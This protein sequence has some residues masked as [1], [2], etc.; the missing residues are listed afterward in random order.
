[1][2]D[3]TSSSAGGTSAKFGMVPTRFVSHPSF[4][5]L[6]LRADTVDEF[7]SDQASVSR[8]FRYAYHLVIEL[9]SGPFFGNAGLRLEELSR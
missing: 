7:T 3:E 5:G 8:Q 2:D 1:M 9:S 6:F 4:P